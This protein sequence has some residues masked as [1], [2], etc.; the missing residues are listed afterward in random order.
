MRVRLKLGT[1][2]EAMVEFK[3]QKG[4]NGVFGCTEKWD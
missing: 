1:S 3:R 4:Q 2:A